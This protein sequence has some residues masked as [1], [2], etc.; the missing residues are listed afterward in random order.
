MVSCCFV[1]R[2]AQRHVLLPDSTSWRSAA[3][4]AHARDEETNKIFY[5]DYVAFL[6]GQQALRKL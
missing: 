1:A 4:L 2:K 5:E 3:F 6:K